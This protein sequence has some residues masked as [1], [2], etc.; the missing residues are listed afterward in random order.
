MN[1][2]AAEHFMSAAPGAMNLP[3]RKSERLGGRGTLLDI[4]T[5]A[6]PAK[7]AC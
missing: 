3:T 5:T 6:L 7:K 4:L 2:W 1:K